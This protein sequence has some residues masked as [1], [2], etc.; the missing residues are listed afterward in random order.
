M[1]FRGDVRSAPVPGCVDGWLALHERYGRLPFAEVLAPASAL[2]SRGFAVSPLL[3][4]ASLLLEGVDGVGEL[5]PPLLAGST[6]RRPG[7]ART[8]DAI[9]NAGRDGF[10][11]GE[12]G[13]Q[14]L[15][16][17]DGEYAPED[18]DRAQAEWVE[19][20]ATT[21]HGHDVWTPPAN[22]QGYLTLLGMAIAADLDVGAPEDGSWAHLLVESARAAGCD[23]D[24]VL[25]D[26]A[27]LSP[28][29]DPAAVAARRGGIDPAARTPRPAPARSGDTMFLCVVDDEGTGVS[30]IQSNAS[31]FGSH[32][33]VGD[34]EVMLHNRGL[35]FSL[36]PGHPAEYG[37]GRRPPH[38]LSPALVTRDDGSLAACV[39]TMGGDQQPQ[40]LLQVLTRLLRHDRDTGDAVGAPRWVLQRPGGSGF[41][42]WRDVAVQ[43]VA[44]EAG[45]PTGWRRALVAAGHEVTTADAHT[46]GHAHAIVVRPDGLEA[47][48][49]PRVGVSLAAGG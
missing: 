46:V 10:Y 16:I 33:A 15:A 29:L 41:D 4:L 26:G 6:V 23:R 12:F 22:S 17:G 48:A 14:L 20:L 27:D 35:G 25:Y 5:S 11:G 13:E 21:V 42:T 8:L 24:A 44:V 39:G 31:G 38:T 32:V 34:T 9:A 47:T 37:P 36:E 1:P 40:I 3:A 28:L 18:L 2:A 30:L 49:D 43:Q 45:A 7:V 19:P